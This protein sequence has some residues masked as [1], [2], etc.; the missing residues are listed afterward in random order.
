MN[1]L[2]IERY[3]AQAAAD[4]AHL[5]AQ[6]AAVAIRNQ[7]VLA[8]G[9]PPHVSRVI[10]EHRSR[11]PNAL[12]H[13][14]HLPGKLLLPAMVNAHS[15]LA[16]SGPGPL[17]YPGN[18]CQWVQMVLDT[19][20]ASPDTTHD[21]I[22]RGI[23]LSKQAGVAALGDI[24]PP[25]GP[26]DLVHH[27]MRRANVQGVS[28]VELIGI[29]DQKQ[30]QARDRIRQV[31]EHA[32]ARKAD[33]KHDRKHEP[34]SHPDSGR[35]PDAPAVQLGLE[36][37]A[38]YSTSH[39]LFQLAARA[40]AD[41][42]IPIATHLA[43]LVE[44]DQIIR[45][46]V[47]PLADL[48]TQRQDIDPASHPQFATGSSPIDWLK[49][50]LETSPWL[51]AHVNY[52]TDQQLQ[53][54]AEANASVVYC[55]L[56]ADYFQ[57]TDHRYRDMLAMGIN[58]CLGTD[59]LICQPP[60]DPQPLSILSAM[61]FLHQRD[62]TDPHTLLAMGTANATKPLRL[63]DG[64]ATFAPGAP[65]PMMIAVDIDPGASTSPLTQALMSHTPCQVITVGG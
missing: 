35:G 13:D 28:F 61:R 43:E 16:L 34:D 32:I 53:I 9:S 60:D 58:V 45:Q 37:H 7:R 11:H 42:G 18:F 63:P 46:G 1:R 14:I 2:V 23:K 6:P 51:L 31:I 65:C 55:P 54:L 36:P 48:L 21:A 4:A 15:H 17:P 64:F 19:Q 40:A 29:D 22:D 41:H 47:G 50:E 62:G 52:A 56:A 49:T 5:Q 57:H 44:E 38:P 30:A 33:R 8:S 3:T 20:P 59:S 39:E 10:A 27:A 24:G 12:V 25:L 26:I